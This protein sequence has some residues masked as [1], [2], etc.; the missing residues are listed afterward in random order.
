MIKYFYKD[1]NYTLHLLPTTILILPAILFL[2]AC[3]PDN[4]KEGTSNKYFDIKGYFTNSVKQL[5]QKRSN[6]SKTVTHN[7]DFESRSVKINNW[8]SELAL[9]SESDINK[10]AW[11]DSYSVTIT[12]NETIYI[13]KYSELKTRRIVISK[14]TTGK[15]LSIRI[16]NQINNALYKTSEE[17]HY[18][19]DSLYSIQKHQKILFLGANNYKI[20]GRFN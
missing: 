12:P 5:T 15:V 10:P 16:D 3:K 6:I 14:T 9:F 11:Q 8:A 13:A 20:T 4:V 18:F 7:G 19:P 17:L 1:S 2:S